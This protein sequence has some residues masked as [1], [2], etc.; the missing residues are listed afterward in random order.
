MATKPPEQE[1]KLTDQEKKAILEEQELK[2]IQKI[3]AKARAAEETSGTSKVGEGFDDIVS[4]AESVLHGAGEPET[5]EIPP[6]V[7]RM[8][9]KRK[10][11]SKRRK[12]PAIKPAT[13]EPEPDQEYVPFSLFD[14]NHA[15]AH[16]YVPELVENYGCEVTLLST[17]ALF[18]VSKSGVFEG[19]QKSLEEAQ[20]EQK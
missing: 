3:A 12:A 15:V 13:K 2:S 19:A 17:I 6:P 5:E 1:K 7:R 11:K 4:E 14:K 8:P 18:L 20:K 16:K 10:T 9:G